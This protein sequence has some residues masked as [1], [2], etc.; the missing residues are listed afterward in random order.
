MNAIVAKCGHVTRR[1]RR[2]DPLTRSVLEFALSLL[3]EP[4]AD[5]YDA[6][7]AEMTDKLILGRPLTDHEAHILL[8]VLLRHVKLGAATQEKA[9]P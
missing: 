3:P 9:K 6:F 8:D 7:F 2:K 4:G 5:A 1:I